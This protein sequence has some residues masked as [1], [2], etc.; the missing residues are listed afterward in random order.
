MKKHICFVGFGDVELV[1]LQPSLAGL[2]AVWEC[3]FLADEKAATAAMAERPL[4]AVVVNLTPNGLTDSNFLTQAAIH[5]PGTLRFVL[6]SVADRELIVSCMGAA[7]Q[8]ISR[9]WKGPELVSIIERS[10]ALDA[11]LSNDKLRSFIPRLGNLPGLPATYFE[12]LKKAESPDSTPEAVADVIAR[13]PSLTAR[14][15]QMVNSPACAGEQKISC[16]TEAVTRLGLET[17]KAMVLCLQV[18]TETTQVKGAS[19]SLESLWKHSFSVAKMASKIISH[20]IGSERMASDAYTAGLLH[21]IG[22]IILATNLS[23][24][25][26]TVLNVAKKQKRALQEVELELMGVTSSQVG[27][28]LL[29]LWGLPLP[30]VEATALCRTPELASPV[31][32]SILTVVHVANVLVAEDNPKA[33]GYPLPELNEA[34]LATLDLPRKTDAWRKMLAKKTL[35]GSNTAFRQRPPERPPPPKSSVT[36][37]AQAEKD[38]VPAGRVSRPMTNPGAGGDR[39]GS[40]GSHQVEAVLL[41]VAASDR[42]RGCPGT[43][44]PKPDGGAARAG[45]AL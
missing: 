37:K 26:G 42:R 20:S 11:W 35:N 16:P 28:Y 31:E 19:M 24:E 45:I 33:V 25:Y 10:L 32:F 40:R 30:V 44:G 22:Q 18:F 17:V 41:K 27:A 23:K 7:H 6:G 2:N 12:V 14:L 36:R 1:A 29:G 8:F 9:P 13:D 38:I 21:N 3:A 43:A 39:C 34:Y 4:D 15:L 5:H